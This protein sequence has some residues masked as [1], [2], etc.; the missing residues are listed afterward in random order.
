VEDFLTIKE[1][2][3]KLS[4]SERTILRYIET[5]KLRASK[6]GQWRIRVADIETFFDENA[7]K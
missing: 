6:I 2:A 4:V 1:A 7:N 5:K 3:E